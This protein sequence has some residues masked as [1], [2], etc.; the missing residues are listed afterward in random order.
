MGAT[1]VKDFFGN[2]LRVG[3]RVLHVSR[4]NSNLHFDVNTVT[5]IVDGS[6]W[7]RMQPTKWNPNPKISRV[8]YP[9]RLV[10]HPEDIK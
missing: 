9:E 10:V 7:T 4:V 8:L 1:E 2:K 6:V 5:Q 3:Q